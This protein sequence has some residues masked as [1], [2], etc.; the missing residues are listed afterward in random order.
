MAEI[1]RVNSPELDS[2]L[3]DKFPVL[4][5]GFIRVVD[6]S[7]ADESIVQAARVSCG[8]GTKK[9][10]EDEELIRYLMRHHHGTP[11]E[12][13]HIKFHVR[14]PMDCWRQW[15]RHRISSVNERSS[16]Y[17]IID[18]GAQRAGDN[19]WRV[20]AKTNKQGSGDFFDK[21]I[22]TQF[23]IEETELHARAME[24]YNNRVEQGM[25][26]EQARKDL[27]LCSYTE[28]YWE[29]NL[30]SLLN[31]LFLRMDS[32]AQY[33]IRQYANVIGNEIVSKW[34]PVAWRGFQDYQQKALTLSAIEVEM[35]KMESD[36]ERFHKAVEIGWVPE[37]F[38][39]KFKT[40]D[41]VGK[42]PF[43]LE[44][45][46][47]SAKAKQLGLKD[48]FYFIHLGLKE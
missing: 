32:H 41:L 1:Q 43:N 9:S 47:F 3:G 25:A 14:V 28:A 12:M 10:L 42:V 31:F 39:D 22:G 18:D 6:Y 34:V 29:V 16:R 20:Q 7:G 19:G 2:I 44:R 37:E 33:E 38:A 8:K 4:N 45:K 13:C 40:G 35:I 48:P 27:P 30:R 21:D 24:I 11:L 15:I 23:S 36:I 26:R 5:D 17:S 46:E